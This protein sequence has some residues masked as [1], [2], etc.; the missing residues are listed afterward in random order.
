MDEQKRFLLAMILSGLILG[1]YFL[2]FVKPVEK[3]AKQQIKIEQQ[4]QQAE[5]KNPVIAPID[6]AQ[7]ISS[8]ET[9]IKIETPSYSGSFSH[10]RLPL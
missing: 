7:L 1:G 5:I 2:F 8:G 10:Q 4:I 6:R 3:A 9:R